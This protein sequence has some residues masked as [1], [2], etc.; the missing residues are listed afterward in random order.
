MA[1]GSHP[2]D[3]APGPDGIVWYTAQAQ[4]SLGRFDPAKNS[5]IQIPL[6]AG[7]SPHGVVTGPDGAAWVTDTGQNA[8]VRV[9]SR[10]R[11]V[12]RF[13][14]AGGERLGMHTAVFD[15]DGTLWFTGSA[16]FYGRLDTERGKMDVFDAPDGSGP[17]GIT[18]TPSGDVYFASLSRSYVARVDPRSG[19]ATKLELP[20]PDQGARRVWSDSKG[21]IWV[22]EWNA[23]KLARYDAEAN[24]WREWDMP[25]DSQ[26]YAVFV[27]DEDIVWISDFGTNA[28][29][30]FDP[31]SEEFTSVSLP[32]DPGNVRQILGREGEVWGAESAADALVVIRT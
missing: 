22:T 6:G 10:T 23:G 25:G 7:S 28:I 12:R 8:I 16:G 1:P 21:C 18:A 11:Q 14:P 31:Q 17:Y 2:H 24:R 29:V 30:R 20:T 27:D 9:D 15:R 5:G 3:V 13:R 26:P 32:A 4:G 19:A